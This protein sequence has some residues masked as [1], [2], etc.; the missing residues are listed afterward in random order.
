MAKSVILGQTKM[1]YSKAIQEITGWS[2][3][4]FETQKRLMRY[5][6]ER[7]NLMTGSNLS[8]I[9]QLFYR[10]RFEDKQAY[11]IAQ[12]KEALELNPLQHAIAR[13][14]TGKLSLKQGS[15]AFIQAESVAKEF[16]LDRFSGLGQS[17]TEA[18]EILDLLKN[19]EITPRQAKAELE[20]IAERMRNLKET[21]PEEWI[22]A[23][24]EGYG[25]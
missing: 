10:V 7:F 4:E 6:V 25:S 19:D 24:N 21:S 5:R 23:H 9:E 13:M 17:F 1:S 22:E 16:I 2:K 12:G 18:R 3:K 8:P 20:E 15:K 11:Y 14:K